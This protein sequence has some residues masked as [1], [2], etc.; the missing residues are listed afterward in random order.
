MQIVP[1]F[2]FFLSLLIFDPPFLEDLSHYISPSNRSCPPICWSCR[3]LFEYSSHQPHSQ[4][5]CELRQPRPHCS[6]VISSLM[7][8]ERWLGAFNAEVTVSPWIAP[9]PYPYRYPTIFVLFLGV[10]W[11]AAFNGV[12]F[13]PSGIWNAENRIV[14]SNVSRLFE[15]SLFVLSHF[16]LLSVGLG[17]SIKLAGV[18]KFFGPHNN[19]ILLYSMA[20]IIWCLTHDCIFILTL[21]LILFSIFFPKN[22]IILSIS[23]SLSLSVYIYIYIYNII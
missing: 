13:F 23:L 17:L 5:L 8:P 9:T 6:E 11:E 18:V 10:L 14:L 22:V 20:W 19:V 21:L 2:S 3:S 16:F 12:L 7:R 1:V 15:L 4:T